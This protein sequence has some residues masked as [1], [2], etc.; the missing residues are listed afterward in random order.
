MLLNRLL[1]KTL[2]MRIYKTISLSVLYTRAS[3]S[4]A[5]L[6]GHKLQVSDKEMHW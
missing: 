5:L 3:G 2:N 1:Y 6:E 4:P